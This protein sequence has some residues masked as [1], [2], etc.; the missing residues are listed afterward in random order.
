MGWWGCTS[1]E[2]EPRVTWA[3]RVYDTLRTLPPE[4]VV[5]VVDCHI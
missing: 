5:T 4:T 2:T 3:K 1:D